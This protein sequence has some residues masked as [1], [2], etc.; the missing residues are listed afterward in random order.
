MVRIR[1]SPAILFIQYSL[2]LL[3][4]LQ[5]LVSLP[6]LTIYWWLCLAL[7]LVIGVLIAYWPVRKGYVYPYLIVHAALIVVLTLLDQDFMYMAFNFSVTA[8][9]LLSLRKGFTVTGVLC[10]VLLG[11]LGFRSGIQEVFYPGMILVAGSFSFAY[12]YYMQ[13]KA[14]AERKNAQRLLDELRVT[15]ARLEEYAGQAQELA[16]VDERNRLA[17]ELHDSV[18]QQAFAAS[19]QLGTARTLLSTNPAAAQDHLLKAEALMDEVRSELGQ[20][21]H[22]LRPV[23]L[24]DKGL[25]NALREWAAGWSQQ[26]GILL[27]VQVQ[28]ERGLPLET[29]Q[30]LFRITQ[31]ALSNVARHSQARKAEIRLAYDRQ[32][33]QLSICDDGQG[34]VPETL[35]SGI[36]MQSMR[37]RAGQL[38]DGSIEINSVPGQGTR[39][40]VTCS[41]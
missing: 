12:A 31:E 37:E 10:L 40:V 9:L 11:V 2:L 17:R 36:G 21:I 22:A 26:C 4:T 29:E 30:A 24:Q 33:V 19:A 25:P 6:A 27:D 20:L 7:A 16:A 8:A 15:H 14:E 13:E 5:A 35:T 23:A 39:I 18:K 34:F 28:G 3:F 32:M 41:A 38:A 1:N